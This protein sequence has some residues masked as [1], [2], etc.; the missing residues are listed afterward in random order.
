MSIERTDPVRVTVQTTQPRMTA[1]PAS[2]QFAEY[3]TRNGAA[4]VTGALHTLTNLPG[5]ELVTAAVRGPGVGGATT[6]TGTAPPL[7]SLRPEGPGGGTTETPGAGGTSPADLL[8]RSQELSAYY[9]QLQESIGQE[10]RRYTALSNVL[11]VR[12]ESAKNAISNV[13]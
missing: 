12:H 1:P 8:N 3:L 6:T 13:R 7:T 10:N 5:G 9:L 11:H 2:R 4:L